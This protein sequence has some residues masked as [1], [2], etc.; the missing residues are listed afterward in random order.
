MKNPKTFT[1]EID[2]GGD[3]MQT[4]NDVAGVLRIL[5]AEL[6]A[7]YGW[8]DESWQIIDENGNRAGKAKVT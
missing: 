2:L 3:A 7:V 6:E 4:P 8:G 1:V 5:A